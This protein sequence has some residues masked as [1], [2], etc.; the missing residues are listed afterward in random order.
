MIAG[1]YF[2]QFQKNN[3]ISLSL[4][5]SPNTNNTMM[6]NKNMEI[7]FTEKGVRRM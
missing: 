2:F 3:T 7:I 1:L 4:Q 5:L 6:A